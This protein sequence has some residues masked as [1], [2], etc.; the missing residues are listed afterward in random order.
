M[1][2]FILRASVLGIALIIIGQNKQ[3]KDLERE[4]K[5]LQE[6]LNKTNS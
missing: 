4:N 5:R 2:Y 6:Q 3:I 1:F